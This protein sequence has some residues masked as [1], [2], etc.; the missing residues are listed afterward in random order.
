M[1]KVNSKVDSAR[2]ATRIAGARN[3]A[4]RLTSASKQPKPYTTAIVKINLLAAEPGQH[5]HDL[6]K[7]EE[8]PTA[9]L[10]LAREETEVASAV[11]RESEQLLNKAVRQS[12][13]GYAHWDTITGEYKSISTEY[14]EI[15]GY[16]V[17]EF[18]DRFR[19]LDHD[20][21]LVHPEDRAKVDE[22]NGKDAT[23]GRA[24]EY[25][26]I[27]RDGSIIDVKEIMR[28]VLNDKGQLVESFTTL[29]DITWVKVAQQTLEESESRHKQAARLAHIGHWVADEQKDKYCLISNEYARIHGYTLA[30][31]MERFKTIAED[32]Q[33]IHPEDREYTDQV[34]AAG[35][36]AELEFRI[37][38]RDGSIRHVREYY[39]CVLDAAGKLMETR[40]TLQDITE[41]KL[42]ELELREAKEAAEAADLAKSNF[43]ANM[44]HEI[45]T[46]MNAIVGLTHLVLQSDLSAEQA[47]RLSKIEISTRH[48]LDVINNILDFSKAESG[49]LN[50]EHRNFHLDKLFEYVL[51]TLREQVEHKGLTI[52]ADLTEVPVCLRGDRTRLR[53][54][55]LNYACNAVKFTEQGTILLNARVIQERGDELLIRFE[56]KDTGIGIEH[57]KMAGLF[58]MFEQA[59]KSTTRKY[60]G[61]GLGLAITRHL[62]HLMGGE[63]GVESEPGRGSTFWFTAWLGRGHDKRPSKASVMI[64]DAAERL[65]EH[66]TEARVLLVEDNVINLE[67]A[68]ELL[69][70]VGLRV[71]TAENGRDAVAMVER[72]NYALILM[73]VQ[74]PEMDGLAATRLIRSIPGTRDL[75]ILAMTA[76]IF[77]DDRLACQEAGMNGFVA[78][79]VDP[80]KL[81]STIISWLPEPAQN[82]TVQTP[83]QAVE[84]PPHQAPTL[85]SVSSTQVT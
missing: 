44:S 24:L 59:D 14:A 6:E 65:R 31:F 57:D 46:P 79:P 61:T 66:Y 76:S 32:R 9:Q 19:T 8:K 11:L 18:M 20:M 72:S 41:T 67:V 77:K 63:A 16:T 28:D 68:R 52:K 43:V 34:Y 1:N 64:E 69:K 83:K 27:R 84:A 70:R 13:L 21:E 81:Y 35:N 55:L 23:H 51:S 82:A 15:L 80:D 26:V 4:T 45:R 7:L 22:F 71:D 78:K 56:V 12:K 47:E 74:M 17:D 75:P 30:E 5:C 25:R 3:N 29:E 62:A 39:R 38:H 49:K 53:Q 48:L 73:D 37:I 42:V 36:D 58:E 33:N 2:I 60:G 50:I 54:S 85:A 40:G 10:A